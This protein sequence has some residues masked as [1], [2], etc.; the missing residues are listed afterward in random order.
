[1]SLFRMSVRRRLKK[2]AIKQNRKDMV[3]WNPAA[4]RE[5]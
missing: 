2:D 4:A 1:M 3:L 5:N